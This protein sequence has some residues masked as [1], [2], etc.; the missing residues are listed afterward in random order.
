MAPG[1]SCKKAEKNPRQ[2]S[3]EVEGLVACRWGRTSSLS[4]P[5]RK[6]MPVRSTLTVMSAEVGRSHHRFDPGPEKNRRMSR[7]RL[8]ADRAE[9]IADPGAKRETR[10]RREAIVSGALI[11][12]ADNDAMRECAGP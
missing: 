2:K 3:E 9:E 10:V 12:Q 11:L 1:N 8:H 4:C 7:P 6:K 5:I